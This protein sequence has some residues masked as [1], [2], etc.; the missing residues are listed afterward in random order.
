MADLCYLPWQNVLPVTGFVWVLTGLGVPPSSSEAPQWGC[1]WQF[2]GGWQSLCPISLV[3]CGVLLRDFHNHSFWGLPLYS[4]GWKGNR[5]FL[6]PFLP[7]SDNRRKCWRELQLCQLVSCCPPRNSCR[8]CCSVWGA[9]CSS[10][11]LVSSCHV[12]VAADLQIHRRWERPC[13]WG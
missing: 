9:V 11:R 7:H 8:H 12:H 1:K 3:L 10:N 4:L 6:L 2:S 13:L 5:R